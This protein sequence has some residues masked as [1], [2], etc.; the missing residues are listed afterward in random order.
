MGSDKELGTD[1]SLMNVELG[2]QIDLQSSSKFL[3]KV[4]KL[5]IRALNPFLDTSSLMDIHFTW[6]SFTLLKVKVLSLSE[7]NYYVFLDFD[8]KWQEPMVNILWVCGFEISGATRK[9]SM[10]LMRACLV[11]KD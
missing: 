8:N 3:K 7:T 6:D 11:L 10:N 1:G 9:I 2:Q 5:K 4:V